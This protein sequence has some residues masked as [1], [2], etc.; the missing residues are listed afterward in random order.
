MLIVLQEL[1]QELPQ[2][3][4]TCS[5]RMDDGA[6][7]N[8]INLAIEFSWLAGMYGMREYN[9]GK[10]SPWLTFKWVVTVAQRCVRVGQWLNLLAVY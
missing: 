6:V 7:K 1:Q 3:N 8:K 9:K 10:S 2:L 4:L 5:S